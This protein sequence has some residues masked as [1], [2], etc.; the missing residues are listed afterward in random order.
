MTT[1]V[2]KK[3]LVG[4][5]VVTSI[6]AGSATLETTDYNVFKTGITGGGDTLA[7]PVTGLEDG[8]TYRI[9]D[10]GG[11][12]GTDA[13][14]IDPTGA[15][16]INGA[17]TVSIST[18]YGYVVCVWDDAGSQ[19]LAEEASAGGGGGATNL[20]IGTT[21]ATTLNINSDT[22]TNA[23]IPAAVASTSAGLLTGADKAKL[24]GIEAA[25]DVTDATNVDAAGAVME[26][27]Y[28]PAFS[29]LAQQSG[30]GSPSAVSI[31][32]NEILGRITGG[33]S[34]IE[35]LSA[36]DVRS[37]I[38]V[39]NGA[40][41]TDTANVTSAGAL[42]DSE[43]DADIKTLSLPAST[44]ISTFGASLVDDASASAAR[45]TLGLEI[46]TDV[47]AYVS[48][49]GTSFPGSP[50]EGQ[51]FYRTDLDG[52]YYYDSSRSKWLSTHIY[53]FQGSQLG[54]V[55]NAYNYLDAAQIPYSA[56]LGHVAPVDLCIVEGSVVTAA[57]ST[58]TLQLRD[59]GSSVATVSLSAAK[60]GYS[61]TLN[62]STIAAGSVIS[63]YVSGT[64]S[65]GHVAVFHARR[66]ET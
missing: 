10:A 27:D 44:T 15:T 40:D 62:S 49:S 6:A 1:K 32:T 3:M 48:K 33:G 24:D 16:T 63:I 47:E 59:D 36:S 28:T 12:A 21:T 56:S 20:S 26:S 46:G 17:A 43:V 42:M 11:N 60:V 57:T 39:E 4:G 52:E 18:D 22:G 58:C 53:S 5:Q 54:A 2:N 38:N 45:T 7:L 25:A 65:G 55:T 50:T 14:T 41:V 29:I 30:T 13:L 35:G 51:K 9:Y 31:G 37:L 34:Q 64:A 23:T 8:A 19:W 61:S 66:V